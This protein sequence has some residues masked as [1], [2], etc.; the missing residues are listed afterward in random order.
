MPDKIPTKKKPKGSIT[1]TFNCQEKTLLKHLVFDWLDT[2][3]KNRKTN[4]IIQR[5]YTY[6]DKIYQKITKKRRCPKCH[7][8]I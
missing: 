8:F 6:Y 4:R 2:N 1:I 5:D 3:G 7:Q